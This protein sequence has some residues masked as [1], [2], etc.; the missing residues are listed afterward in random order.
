MF[1]IIAIAQAILHYFGIIGI[2]LGIIAYLFGNH[3]RGQELF[4]GGILFIILKYLIGFIYL[5]LKKLIE[6]K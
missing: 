3:S 5:F 6:K 1:F 2:V 4:I